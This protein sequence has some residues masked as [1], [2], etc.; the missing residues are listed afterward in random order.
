MPMVLFI[1]IRSRSFLQLLNPKV[2][3]TVVGS[4]LANLQKISGN[5]RRFFWLFPISLE[6]CDKQNTGWHLFLTYR[7]TNDTF[8]IVKYGPTNTQ[9]SSMELFGKLYFLKGIPGR[10]WK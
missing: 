3:E 7:Q 8:N 5:S 1:K 10:S 9:L 4:N 6:Y 2:L